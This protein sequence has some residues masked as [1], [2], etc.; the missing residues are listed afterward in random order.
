MIEQILLLP[1]TV[2][3]TIVKQFLEMDKSSCETTEPF[4]G[5]SALSDSLRTLNESHRMTRI[6]DET[7]H[8]LIDVSHGTEFLDVDQAIT[9]QNEIMSSMYHFSS[10][11]LEIKVPIKTKPNGVLVDEIVYENAS[12]PEDVMTCLLT[13]H[14]Q[15]VQLLAETVTITEPSKPLLAHLNSA[16]TA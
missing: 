10:Q 3:C 14:E 12:I 2:E 6:V 8:A 9:R 4:N 16:T 13:M 11:E 1:G 15:T 5:G 7:V